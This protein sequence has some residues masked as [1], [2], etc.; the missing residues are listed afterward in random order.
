MDPQ[1]FFTRFPPDGLEA[2]SSKYSSE[3]AAGNFSIA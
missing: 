1:E 3:K 2:R